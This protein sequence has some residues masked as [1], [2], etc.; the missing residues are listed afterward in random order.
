M[1]FGKTQD[2]SIGAGMG[3]PGGPMWYL[4]D[5]KPRKKFHPSS[6][7]LPEAVRRIFIQ[8]FVR[9]SRQHDTMKPLEEY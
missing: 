5:S 2:G 9:M 7:I 6:S 4:D 8:L 1:G 3:T